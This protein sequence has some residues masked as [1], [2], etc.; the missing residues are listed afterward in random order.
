[1]LK[2]HSRCC[3]FGETERILSV[4]KFLPH[5]I[6]IVGEKNIHDGDTA[7][8]YEF[9]CQSSIRTRDFHLYRSVQYRN[10]WLFPFRISN[11]N[12]IFILSLLCSRYPS[13]QGKMVP[14]VSLLSEAGRSNV[15]G[16]S[17]FIFLSVWLFLAEISQQS[18]ARATTMPQLDYHAILQIGIS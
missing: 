16:G 3:V 1:M 6:N 18:Q 12:Y 9:F 5:D 14:F 2:R 13:S 7:D 8:C 4:N 17:I 10:R 15:C 11:M